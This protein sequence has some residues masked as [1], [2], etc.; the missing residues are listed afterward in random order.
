M[1]KELSSLVQGALSAEIVTLVIVLFLL[2]L[3][4]DLISDVVSGLVFIFGSEFNEGD[5]I[6]IDGK[7]AVI[8]SV[9][10]RRA[11]FQYEIDG[12]IHWEVVTNSRVKFLHITKVVGDA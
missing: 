7:R 5:T 6:Y 4:K 2:F 1:E 10:L 12:K 8:I 11:K 3:I 9:G